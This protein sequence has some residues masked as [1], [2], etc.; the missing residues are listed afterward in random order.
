MT[1]P[2]LDYLD[3]LQE[4]MNSPIA[5]SLPPTLAFKIASD[6]EK[7]AAG[8]DATDVTPTAGIQMAQTG[9]TPE[10]RAVGGKL[11]DLA[12]S[13]IS[14]SNYTQEQYKYQAMAKH[15]PMWL[16]NRIINRPAPVPFNAKI[17]QDAP[18][19]DARYASTPLNEAVWS[20][21]LGR[22]DENHLLGLS[23]FKPTTSKDP[24][25]VY[26]Q[27][28]NYLPTLL[29]NLQY[30]TKI[31]EN[32]YGVSRY[33]GRSAALKDLV[34]EVKKAGGKLQ[35]NDDIVGEGALQNFQLTHGHDEIGPYLA[36][37]D[38][39]DLHHV[40]GKVLGK[41]YEVYDR[42]YYDPK[43]FT[44]IPED[45]VLLKKAKMDKELTIIRDWAAK[46]L[47]GMVV[48]RNQVTHGNK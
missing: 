23:Q 20:L 5:G 18:L 42:M 41:P 33:R 39:W 2:R 48:N 45:Q 36:Y 28:K 11:N 1:G 37:Y 35:L 10:R 12:Y 17:A 46:T 34:T 7:N 30:E 44:P 32:G 47:P 9:L 19:A 6:L 31:D 8:K 4:L 14:P 16:L 25:A 29:G 40:G 38:I 3:Q 26:Y 27:I 21:Y 43:T 22:P 24:N 13:L 15:H